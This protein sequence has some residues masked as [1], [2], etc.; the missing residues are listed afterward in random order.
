MEDLSNGCVDM[1]RTNV[2]EDLQQSIVKLTINSK[3]RLIY[4]SENN[5]DN[6]RNN[7]LISSTARRSPREGHALH[8]PRIQCEVVEADP[9]QKF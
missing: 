3:L 4:R 2:G 8:H 7:I 9:A 6:L 1:L 5:H